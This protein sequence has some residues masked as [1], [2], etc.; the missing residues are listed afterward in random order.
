MRLEDYFDFPGLDVIRLKGHRLG[1]EDILE[2]YNAGYTPEQIVLE[3]PDLNLE[4]IHA[5]ITYYWR[6][7]KDVE[8]YLLRLEKQVTASIEK[9]SLKEAPDVIKRIRALQA[10]ATAT[11]Y[12]FSANHGNGCFGI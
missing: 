8:A 7:Q 6:N 10:K 4:Q 1:I 2:L 12:I 5:T 9:E 11:G 3:Y